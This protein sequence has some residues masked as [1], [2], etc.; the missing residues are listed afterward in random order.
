M[1]DEKEIPLTGIPAVDAAFQRVRGRFRDLE[2]A[3][4]VSAHLEANAGRR[5]KE[6]AEFLVRHEEFLDRHKALI[7][8]HAIKMREIDE[9]LNLMID[10]EMRRE[11]GPEASPS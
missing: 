7:E 4:L 1:A 9:K 11:G 3:M 5:I 6:H 8:E 2:D 10:R